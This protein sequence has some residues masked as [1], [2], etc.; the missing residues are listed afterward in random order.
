MGKIRIVNILLSRGEG[1]AENYFEKLTSEFQSSGLYEQLIIIGGNERREK[2]LRELGCEVVCVDLESIRRSQVKKKVLKHASQFEPQVQMAW[3]SHSSKKMSRIQG[4]IN[5]SRIGGYYKKKYFKT[6]QQIVINAPHL[7]SYLRRQKMTQDMKIIV[8][9]GDAVND[10]VAIDWRK[11]LGIKGY[12]KLVVSVGR[13]VKI[14]WH[15]TAIKA[16]AEL[17]DE[18]HLAIAGSGELEEKLRLLAKDLGVSHRVH[19]LGWVESMESLFKQADCC[20]FPTE[21]E[22]SG[23]PVVESWKFKTPIIAGRADGPLWLIDE[24]VNGMLVDHDD[25]L[26]ASQKVKLVLEDTVF[27]KKMVDAAYAKYEAEFSKEV[28]L[29]RWYQYFSGLLETDTILLSH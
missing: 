9:Y 28:I 8:N 5:V 10:Q 23:S 18:C 26:V 15:N 4:C 19:F 24:G 29:K 25:Y 2:R 14:K 6:A 11:K 1:G 27:A 7:E 16:I 17:P 3:M 13:L 12:E 20:L 21:Q 22:A